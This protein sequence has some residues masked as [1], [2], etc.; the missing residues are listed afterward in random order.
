MSSSGHTQ[1][2]YIG[3][4]QGAT[5]AL[6]ALATDDVSKRII[7]SAILL[8][9]AAFVSHTGSLLL[10]GLADLQADR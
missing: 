9:P 5:I 7:D 3:H 1:V 4:S 10:R 6:A 2:H 8:A